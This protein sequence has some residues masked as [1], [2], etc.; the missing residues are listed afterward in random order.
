MGGLWSYATE[1]SLKFSRRDK[2]MGLFSYGYSL[3]DYKINITV[4]R[5]RLDVF[6]LISQILRKLISSVPGSQ[7]PGSHKINVIA[8]SS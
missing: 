3:N 1:L 6:I 8:F 7:T 5:I 4:C 2:S